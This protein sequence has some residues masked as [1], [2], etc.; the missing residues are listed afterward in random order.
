M[1]LDTVPTGEIH[2]ASEP[3]PLVDILVD[4]VAGGGAVT[5]I[6]VVLSTVTALLNTATNRRV[7]DKLDT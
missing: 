3:K 5:A 4:S 1:P 7:V 2:R 6:V